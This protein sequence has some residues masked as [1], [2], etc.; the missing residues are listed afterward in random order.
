MRITSDQIDSLLAIVYEKTMTDFTG[1]RRAT[2]S[3]RLSERLAR[4]GMDA[5]Q[6][7]SVCRDDPEECAKLVSAI[8]INVSAFF[9]DSLVFE[10]IARSVLPQLVG[11]KGELR[12]WSAGGAAGE[13]AYSIAIL[14]REQ[15][16]KNKNT[17]AQPIIF[18]T[19]IDRDVLEKA[20]KASY[21]RE[22]LKDVKLGIVDSWF[23]PA[24]DGFD[25]CAE[26]KNMVYFSSDDLLSQKNDAPA[27][28]IYG[29]FDLILCRNVLIY[30]SVEQQE[31]V[32]VKLYKSLANG[33][34]LVL[35]DSETICDNFKARF[36]TVDARTKI[37][38]K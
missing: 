33:G 18:A 19:D 38:Q 6:Y 5:E 20:R 17:D 27:E 15:L 11:R 9:R 4:L 37:Y 13:E 21:P 12:V 30:F 36:K 3:R 26:I 7:I 23:S 29:S 35:G 28:S 14:I 34:Y 16:E 8:A 1:Y 31:Q 2:L 22:S 25:L 32:F 10:M 24:K